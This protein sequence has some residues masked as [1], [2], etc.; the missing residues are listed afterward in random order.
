[1]PLNRRHARIPVAIALL[2][3]VAFAL[4]WAGARTPYVRGLV[5]GAITDAVGLPA[6]VGRLHLGFIPSPRLDIGGIAV[7]Q[8]PGFG[9]ESLLEIERLEVVLPWRRLFGATDRI[10]ALTVSNATARLRVS[11]DGA[12][13]WSKLFQEPPTATAPAEPARWSIGALVLEG[14]TIDYRDAATG[15]HGQLTAITVKANDVVPSAAFP[16]ELQLG[17]IAGPN[18]IHFALKGEAKMDLAAGLYEASELEFR[19]WLGGDPLPLAGAELTG[20]LRQA[21]FESGTGAARFAGGQFKFAEIP[22]RFDGTLDLDEPA[23]A[24]DLAITTEA[25]AP[26][27]P[28]I[29]LGQALPVTED[30]AAFESLQVALRARMTDGEIAFDPLSGRLDDTNFEGRVLPGRRFVRASL[31]AIDFNRYLPPAAKSASGASSSKKA[32][33]ESLANELTRLDIDAELRIGEARIGD[34]KVRDAVI[35]I[36]PDDEAAP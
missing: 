27:A 20:E 31:D 17:G 10:D 8:P 15:T 9:A 28:A 23:V 7:A 16:L 35:R 30:P 3:V 1:M 33:L 18:T 19:G 6:Q 11:A 22:G 24:A 5:A 34:A 12:S 32:T 25:F 4:L 21:S 36:T 13:N 14:G 2:A 29:I 26:R